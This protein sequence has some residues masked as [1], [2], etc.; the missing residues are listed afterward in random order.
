MNLRP[1]PALWLLLAVSALLYLP[2]TGVIPLMDR[3]E[4]RFAHATV[5]MMQREEWT[6]PYFNGEY[7]FDKPP[8]TY[9]W[10]RLHFMLLGVNEFSARLHS[11]ISV[12]LIAW[13]LFA[14][15]RRLHSSNAGLVGALAWLASMQSLVHGRL[16][17]ADMPMVLFV[18]LSQWALLE[19]LRPPDRRERPRFSRW[20]WVLWLS[21][22]LG[23]LAKGPVA[24]LAPGLGLLLWRWLFWRKA[25][26]WSRLQWRAGLILSLAIVA[27]WGIPA[28]VMTKGLFWNVGMGEHVMKRGTEAFN[29][30]VIIPFYYVGAALF[31]LMPWIAWLPDVWRRLRLDWSGHATFLVS[32]FVAPQLI[33]FFYATQLPHYVMP[34]FPAFFLLLGMSL[35]TMW[36]TNSGRGGIF[37]WTYLGG[38]LLVSSIVMIGAGM[39]ACGLTGD[40]RS[41]VA[42]LGGLQLGL[43]IIGIAS[44]RRQRWLAAAALIGVSV[45]L[46]HSSVLLRRLHPV[47]QIQ[48]VLRGKGEAIAWQ[49][50]EPSL[51]F[52]GDRPWKFLSKLPKVGERMKNGQADVVV[53]LDR[54]W[55]LNHW[56]K[57]RRQ[58]AAVSPDR[59]NST[60]LDQLGSVAS[61]YT[62]TSISG[63]NLAR[64]SWV[65]LRVWKRKPATLTP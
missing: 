35:A 27:A 14:M 18:T 24:W 44:C 59:D 49:F 12:T 6:I 61:S 62:M 28:L 63:L 29:G 56:I 52:Y 36:K 25:L 21:L 17:V 2:A 39:S 32:W 65:E 20:F 15:G 54:E 13:V 23:F 57:S 48:P 11:V 53:C 16:C 3:D 46:S 45:T 41:L 26:P 38:L 10:M 43:A 9:W 8:L 33:F 19:L 60:T 34:G 22:G 7:R 64:S 30:R 47:V 50:T 58:G 51:V 37:R 1:F 4:P 31:S 55:T 42:S 5:E 40:L